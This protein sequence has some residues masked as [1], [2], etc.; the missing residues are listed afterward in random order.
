[1]PGDYHGGRVGGNHFANQFQKPLLQWLQVADGING[2]RDLEQ[3][4]QIARHP[5]N[6][7]AKVQD[8]RQSFCAR[9]GYKIGWRLVPEL[10]NPRN[11]AVVLPDQK[12]QLTMAYPNGVSM[13]QQLSPCLL[14]TSDAADEED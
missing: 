6:V 11:Q 10:R 14:Y 1:M 9:G 2:A 5:A 3:G 13:A 12:H 7:G 8:R 4:I